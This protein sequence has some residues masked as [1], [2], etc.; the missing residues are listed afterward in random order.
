MRV[1]MLILL[2]NAL[3]CSALVA[4]GLRG[5]VPAVQ[6][7]SSVVV[8][9]FG[10]GNYD[11][12]DMP[13]RGLTGIF[14]P[15]AGNGFTGKKGNVL[16]TGK[17]GN[18]LA[19]LVVA[20]SFALPIV[21]CLALVVITPGKQLPFNFLDGLYAPRVEELRKVEE[22]K[23]AI[24]AQEKK[25]KEAEAAKAAKKAAAAAAAKAAAAQTAP[26]AK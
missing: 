12:D 26:A 13:D 11:P 21:F 6:G 5:T 2:S 4:T 7:R 16:D 15:I 9:Q 17:S 8:N 14:S 20:A 24:D 1:G 23:V 19:P 10:T 18:P 25:E 22:K 3:V